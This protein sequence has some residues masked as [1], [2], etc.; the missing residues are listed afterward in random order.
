MRRLALLS[1][2]ILV[3]AGGGLTRTARAGPP[4]LADVAISALTER[5]GDC[6][7]SVRQAAALALRDMGPEAKAAIPALAQRLRDI[8]GYVAI[9]SAQTLKGMGPEAVP[10][11]TPLLRDC[12]PRVRE[13]AVRTLRQIGSEAIS[14]SPLD[15]R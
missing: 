4:Y 11:L 7:A 6:D 10:G 1:I 14:V 5:L 2:M 9:D 3:A 15:R 8:D 13:L 12:E